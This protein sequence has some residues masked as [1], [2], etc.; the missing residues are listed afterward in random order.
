M[1]KIILILTIF[2]SFTACELDVQPETEFTDDN[3]WT[4]EANL[5]SFSF[6][7]Y[8]VFKGYGNGGFFGGDHF[9]STLTDDVIT[10]D[11]RT[12]H[13]FPTTVPATPSGTDWSWGDIRQANVLIDGAK[14]ATVD[15]NVKNKYIGVGRLFRAVLYWEKVREFGDVPFYSTP[16]DA[17]DQDALYKARDSR[18]MVVDNIVADLDFA[19]AHLDDTDDKLE[20]NKWTALA[21]KSRICLAAATTFAYH[22]VAGANTAALYQASYDASKEIMDN[23][24]FSLNASYTELFASESLTGNSE[25]I[26]EKQY[27]ENM[28]HAIHSFIFHEPFFGFTQSAVSSFLMTDGKP[29]A[30]DGATH[31]D[32]TQWVFNTT[33]SIKTSNTTFET[34]VDITNK[35]DKR[36][37]AIVDT[38]RLVFLFNKGIP[39]YSPVKYATYQLI[40]DQPTQGVQGTTDAPILRL[41]EVLLNYAEAAF[42]L[43]NIAQGDLD[44]S[45]NLLRARAGVA[46][47]TMA[48]G[49]DADDRDADVAP[50]LW[51]IRRERRVELMLEPF[52]K[53]DLIRWKNGDYYDD[54]RSFVGVKADP[55]IKYETGIEVMYNADGYLYAQKPE[56]R[57]EPWNDKKYLYPLP[58]DQLVLNSNLTQNSG[59]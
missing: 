3:F 26:L 37:S 4:S 12:E 19:I 43:G 30:Y 25:V 38:T 58:A 53:W 22:N 2:W 29:I 1:K 13:D 16:I 8:K 23:G 27:N 47:L 20:V 17:D 49:F 18:V 33:D 48:V 15:E 57:R 51:E 44:K 28:S 55:S 14:R 6:A 42:E 11:E 5:R 40:I 36:L 9:Y 35:R 32:Y 34:T 56:D 45:I 7:L 50:L 41:G 10:L 31:P 39:M 59:W 54:D 52:R 46:P 21:L 24:P